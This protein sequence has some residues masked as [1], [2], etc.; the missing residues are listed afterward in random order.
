MLYHAALFSGLGGFVLAA[1]RNG[2]KTVFINEVDEA[3][4]ITLKHNFKES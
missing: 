1:E 2:I 3:C 4:C